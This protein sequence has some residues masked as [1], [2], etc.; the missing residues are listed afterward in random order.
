MQSCEFTEA[1]S[2]WGVPLLHDLE[3]WYLQ[4]QALAVL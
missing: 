1:S 2:F 4:R 3:P